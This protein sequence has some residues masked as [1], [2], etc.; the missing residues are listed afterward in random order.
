MFKK[1]IIGL[2][3]C[4]VSS[5]FAMSLNELNDANKSDLMKINGIGEAKATAI[6]KERKNGKFKSFDNLI[7]IKGIGKK[8][9]FNLKNDVKSLKKIVSKKNKKI[10][11]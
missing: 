3:F 7:H 6:L 10:K 5:I 2:L 4:G 1:V 8:I 9:V 11:K